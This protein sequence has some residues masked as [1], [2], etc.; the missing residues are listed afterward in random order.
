MKSLILASILSV[1]L[2]QEQNYEPIDKSLY[3]AQY[4]EWAFLMKQN[5]PNYN[6]EAYEVTAPDGYISTL[7]RLTGVLTDPTY[8]SPR[9]P[10]LVVTGNFKQQTSWI[11]ENRTVNTKKEVRQTFY[12]TF[13]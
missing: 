10:V 2:A 4:P 9:Q 12:D 11:G 1:A 13:F 8:T 3:I 7:F 5:Y 6:W